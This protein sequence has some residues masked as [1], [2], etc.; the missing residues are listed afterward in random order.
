[1]LPGFPGQK[2]LLEQKLQRGQPSEYWPRLLLHIFLKKQSES[3]QNRACVFLLPRL[4]EVALQ[5]PSDIGVK[6]EKSDEENGSPGL[7]DDVGSRVG[8]VT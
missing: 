3:I 2:F 1:M 8:G 4:P 7:I 6:K 5:N